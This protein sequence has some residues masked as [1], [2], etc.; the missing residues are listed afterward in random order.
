MQAVFR[1][2]PS[3]VTHCKGAEMLK[4]REGGALGGAFGGAWKNEMHRK[5]VRLGVHF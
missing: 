2:I 4:C 1:V 5:G 3:F